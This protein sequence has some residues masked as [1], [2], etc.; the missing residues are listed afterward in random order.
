MKSHRI[1]YQ[2]GQLPVFQNRMFG[3]GEE[4]R[5]CAKGDMVLAQDL[6]TGLISNIAFRPEFVEFDENYQNEQ[7]VSAVFRQHLDNVAQTIKTHF[8]GHSLIEV[9][10]G[11][12]HFLE[13]LQELGFD[14][15]GMDPSYE[16]T[17][18]KVMKKYFNPEAGV[19]ADGVILRHVLE[20]VQEPVEFLKKIRDANGGG[21]KIYIEVP[22][23][24]WI[25][26]HRAWFDIFY[27]HVNY[28]RLGDFTRMFGKVYEVGHTFNGQYLYVVANLVTIKEPVFDE[29]EAIE[30]PGDF[31]DSVNRF[32]A[33]LTKQ[34][35]DGGPISAIWGGASKGV[36]FSLLMERA[37]AKID[38]VIDI[39]PAKQAKYLPAT[40]LQVLSP[41]Q[42]MPRLPA[43]AEIF[44][45]NGNYLDEIREI[46][47]NQYNYI[48]VDNDGV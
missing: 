36:I 8:Q 48:R 15:T 32:A 42:A 10:C 40:G 4:A 7:A 37:G 43:G 3:S 27:E 21:G 20:H 23:F 44:V 41:Q 9:G 25:C 47:S 30:F 33:K 38:M 16:G 22:C 26:Q 45:M 2:A 13:Q 35:N 39:N 17:N 24:D 11:K 1:L 34:G 46:T 5:N 18:P 6:R 31:L 12:A 14:I 19:R 29:A 28:F